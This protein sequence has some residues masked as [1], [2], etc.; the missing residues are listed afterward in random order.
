MIPG[1]HL[2]LVIYLR[3][4]CTPL[5]SSN[6]AAHSGLKFRQT[7]PEVQSRDIGGPTKRTHVLQNIFKKIYIV[8]NL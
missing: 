1:I 3:V 6:K 7:S 2:L 5:A 8:I 4:T